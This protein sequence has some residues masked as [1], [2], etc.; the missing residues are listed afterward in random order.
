M[1]I[2]ARRANPE[3]AEQ[4]SKFRL[5]TSECTLGL[6]PKIFGI[7]DM[8]LVTFMASEQSATVATLPALIK[9]RP[10]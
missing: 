8:S 6:D 3:R 7:N 4:P 10:F 9:T 5:L 1:L 2:T